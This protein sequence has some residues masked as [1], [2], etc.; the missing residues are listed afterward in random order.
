MQ[1]D[2]T[3]Y[4]ALSHKAAK[5]LGQEVV[6]RMSPQQL[7]LLDRALDRMLARHKG[8]VETI[9]PAEIEG[10]YEQIMH[11]VLPTGSYEHFLPS[12]G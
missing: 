3:Q 8:N 5:V 12:K 11:H 1:I 2:Q 10:Q 6:D 7:G 4:D 9:T